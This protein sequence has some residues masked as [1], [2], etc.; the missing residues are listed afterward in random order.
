MTVQVPV[1][2]D[3]VVVGYLN[4]VGLT[5]RTKVPGEGEAQPN[6]FVRVVLA[7]GA[8]RRDHVVHEA[9]VIVEAWAKSYAAASTLMRTTDG[10]MHNAPR[11]STVIKRV[12]A[13]SA[14]AELPVPDS[15]YFRLTATY[16]VTTKT[17]PQ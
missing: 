4:G 2:S 10:H 11:V 17:T 9:T 5:A 16:Q 8:G 7:G 15:S 1:A 3:G 13:F 6:E 12:D 14:P